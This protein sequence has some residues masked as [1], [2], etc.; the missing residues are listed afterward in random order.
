M[1]FIDPQGTESQWPSFYP[2]RH[3]V[4]M[5]VKSQSTHQAPVSCIAHFPSLYSS[6]SSEPLAPLDLTRD[7]I[8]RLF[9]WPHPDQGQSGH[10]LLLCLAA[11]SPPGTGGSRVRG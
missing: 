10:I 6:S 7:M 1:G 11:V 5:C 4:A 8:Q 2:R 9:H 3:L